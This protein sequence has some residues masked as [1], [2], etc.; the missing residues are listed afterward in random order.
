MPL[1]LKS[2]SEVI[3]QH[4]I[5]DG[6][7]RLSGITSNIQKLRYVYRFSGLAS[8]IQKLR[9]VFRISGITSYIQKCQSPGF[10]L[11]FSEFKA[12]NLTSDVNHVIY[13][14]SDL[15]KILIFFSGSIRYGLVFTEW[16]LVEKMENCSLSNVPD[17]TH[18]IISVVYQSVLGKAIQVNYFCIIKSGL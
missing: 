14:Y 4:G 5:V 13:M 16:K 12:L 3:E 17:R 8:N 10:W 18:N 2:C 7:Y 6:I 15:F 1:V 9:Y 11:H